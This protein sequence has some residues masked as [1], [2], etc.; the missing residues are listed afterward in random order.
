MIE[1]SYDLHQEVQDAFFDGIHAR[2]N[3]GN[4]LYV[5]FNENST[6]PW[7]V[8]FSTENEPLTTMDKVGK[9]DN[10]T[11]EKIMKMIIDFYN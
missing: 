8:E 10:P 4:I 1:N 5:S 7:T 2:V 6:C 11:V 9:V 3:D